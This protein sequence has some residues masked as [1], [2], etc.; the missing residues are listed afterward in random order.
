MFKNNRKVAWIFLPP[1]VLCICFRVF[2]SSSL[3]R[4]TLSQPNYPHV[5][6]LCII[7]I[8]KTNWWWSKVSFIHVFVY[9]QWVL[10]FC[11][12]DPW[13]TQ[14]AEDTL[15]LKSFLGFSWCHIISVYAAY[16]WWAISNFFQAVW[17]F[18]VC[19]L[20]VTIVVVAATAVQK[21]VAESVWLHVPL[22]KDS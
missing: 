22:G 17:G 7:S 4:V 15:S 11:L 14:T 10:E 6:T 3:G 19:L 20:L 1:S 13:K 9:L 5:G 16:I 18:C 21:T 2:L 8:R 12:F